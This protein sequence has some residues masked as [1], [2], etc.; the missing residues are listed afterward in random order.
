MWRAYTDIKFLKVA[1]LKKDLEAKLKKIQEV[2]KSYTEVLGIGSGEYGIAALTRI[3]MAYA[4]FAQNF[5]DSP[6]PTYKGKP[7]DEEQLE[8]YRGEL[9]NR[10][11]PLEE[12]A[13][14]ALEKALAKSYE[15]NVYNEWTL[16]AQDKMNKYRPGVYGK[17]RDVA[18][19]GSEFFETAPISKEV[20]IASAKEAPVAPAPEKPEAPPA[21]PKKPAPGAST[22]AA[23]RAEQEAQR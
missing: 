8:M 18:Y 11:F 2:E 16:L 13:I 9:E 23:A 12:K 22:A 10:A 4:D 3:G 5:L 7:L 1:T 19:R 17:V 14:E 6:D 15:L 21:D 20:P